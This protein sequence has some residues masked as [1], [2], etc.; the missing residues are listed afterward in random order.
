MRFPAPAGCR[1]CPPRAA[2]AHRWARSPSDARPGLTTRPPCVGVVWTSRRAA[3]FGGLAGL[4]R[5]HIG[6]GGADRQRRGDAGQH[7]GTVEMAVQQQ[8]LDQRPG[9]H[10]VSVGFAGRGPKRVMLAGEHLRLRGLA[11]KRSRRAARRACVA[12]SPDSGPSRGL[13]RPCRPRAD[14]GP[15][16]RC[17]HRR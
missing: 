13:W 16:P 2:A 15:P 8:H 6:A 17:G 5:H 3:A 11:P 4:Q 9:A 10:G 12:G 7:I 14:A 1:T